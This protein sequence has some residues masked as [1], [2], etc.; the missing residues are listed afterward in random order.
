MLDTQ[1]SGFLNLPLNNKG[2]DMRLKKRQ[3]NEFTSLQCAFRHTD[4]SDKGMKMT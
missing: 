3:R 1:L 4:F 2:E